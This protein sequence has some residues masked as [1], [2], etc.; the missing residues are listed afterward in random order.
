MAPAQFASSELSENYIRAWFDDA[1]SCE[2]A[3]SVL[4]ETGIDTGETNF[5]LYD[6]TDSDG[7]GMPDQWEINYF[8]DTS[9]N[10]HGDFNGDGTTDFEEYEL[11]YNPCSIGNTDV[12]GILEDAPAYEVENN[13]SDT[14]SSGSGSG[15][16]CFISTAILK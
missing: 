9:R 11:G 14:N 5:F 1:L 15:G 13:E 16:G 3:D 8:R 2:E 10:G 6:S 12:S 7:D 4:V